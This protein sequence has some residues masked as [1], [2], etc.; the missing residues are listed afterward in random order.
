MSLKLLL[1][2]PGEVD[3]SA[4][5]KA[6][7]NTSDMALARLWNDRFSDTEFIGNLIDRILD[8]RSDESPGAKSLG[9][10]IGF[11]D[12]TLNAIA[13][14][15]F[16]G[17]L[18]NAPTAD[19]RKRIGDCYRRM[20][21]DELLILDVQGRL[22][23][24]PDVSEYWEPKIFRPSVY[25][26]DV[27]KAS[28]IGLLLREKHAPPA[29]V[30]CTVQGDLLSVKIHDLN[31]Y[32]SWN[33]LYAMRSNDDPA[34]QRL[35]AA[36]RGSRSADAAKSRDAWSEFLRQAV[37]TGK[38]CGTGQVNVDGTLICNIKK[39]PRC[40]DMEDSIL[41]VGL[42]EPPDEKQRGPIREVAEKK[43]SANPDRAATE[44]VRAKH[45]GAR[46]SGRGQL[47]QLRKQ[48]D[49]DEHQPEDR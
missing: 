48:L 46:S 1:G 11:G 5:A 28:R 45:G 43:R 10:P 36:D 9:E 12:T 3:D 40:G 24:G 32:R 25:V 41:L 21:C 44:A 4:L 23:C 31:D 2:L 35:L 20:L 16:V 38:R 14:C 33:A 37:Q 22:L 26:Y 8:A 30:V 27:P 39:R 13:D 42:M 34:I 49:A 29:G 47:R 18:K 7:V 19:E 17:T 6:A 15:G